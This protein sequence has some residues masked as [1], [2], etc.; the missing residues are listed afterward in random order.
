MS[1]V[2]AALLVPSASWA[3]SSVPLPEPP[4]KPVTGG[5]G[6]LSV[7]DD[8]EAV[9]SDE[10][11][12]HDRYQAAIDRSNELAAQI[13][14]LEAGIAAVQAEQAV[15][16]ERLAGTEA[17]LA[18]TT[19][20]LSETEARLERET[21]RLRD[22]AVSAYMGG[23][24][25]VPDLGEALRHP[26]SLD[27]F[28]KG[29]VYADAVIADRKVVIA[30]V[31]D[32]RVDVERLRNEAESTRADAAAARDEVAARATDLETRR[33]E[34]TAAE[35][36]AQAAAAV[37]Q[38]LATDLEARRR[39]VELRYANEILESDSIGA[40]LA[41]RQRGQVAPESTFAMFLDP[42]RNGPIVS[43]YGPRIDPFLGTV[44]V[45]AGLDIDGAM[46]E[47]IR[48]SAD[49]VVV[50]AEER[51]GYGNAVVID[52]GNTLATLYGHMS[53]FAVK[54]GDVV[55]RGDVIGLVGSTGRSTGPHCHWEVRVNG[56]R[57]EGSPYLDKTREP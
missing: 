55:R 47:P 48:A 17:Q 38:R 15:A 9:L 25:P 30:R 28:A 12:V 43:G 41:A 26:S 32:M 3:Q 27:D 39:E 10:M 40:I 4:P 36:A 42:I 21:Q 29:R 11:A 8:Y 19:A 51:G 24:T 56:T 37:Q 53:S 7:R 44:K 50:L 57:V 54:A 49:G 33:D 16:E 52:H 5:D 18:E 22:E 31:A 23:G 14:E 1:C 45:H 46:G 6:R 2:V 20:R 13:A 35:Q 34:H